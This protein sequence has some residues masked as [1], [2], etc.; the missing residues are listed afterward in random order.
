[1]GRSCCKNRLE[2]FTKTSA[3]PSDASRKAGGQKLRFKGTLRHNL[4]NASID[5]KNW[6]MIACDRSMWK[7]NMRLGL[8]RYEEGRIDK[9]EEK[10]LMR[11]NYMPQNLTTGTKN[12]CNICHRV[13]R[14]R[15]GLFA[16]ECAYQRQIVNS[17]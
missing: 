8:D 11:H 9:I 6:E 7:K 10:R 2:T 13:C 17:C 5:H 16:R 12:V 3:I 1:M 15:I 14:S 4:Q